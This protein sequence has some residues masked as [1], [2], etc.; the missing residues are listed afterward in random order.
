M[1]DWVVLGQSKLSDRTL[2][3]LDEHIALEEMVVST[4]TLGIAQKQSRE[5][6]FN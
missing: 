6:S 5:E 1:K 2:D 3:R 4:V